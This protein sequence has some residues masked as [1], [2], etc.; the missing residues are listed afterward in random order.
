MIGVYIARDEAGRAVYIGSSGCIEKRLATHGATAPWWTRVAEVEQIETPTRALAYHR[1]R[2]LI[3][4]LDPECNQ[5]AR[6]KA[7]TRSRDLGPVI[8]PRPEVLAVVIDAYGSVAALARAVGCNHMT[9]SDIWRGVHYPSGKVI[10]RLIV[11][12]GIPFD[13]LFYVEDSDA[14]VEQWLAR[15]GRAVA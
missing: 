14:P 2:E 1:E 4:E 3:K 12:T 13:E 5:M 7:K 11:V 9:L 8:R 10:A 15:K 6:G